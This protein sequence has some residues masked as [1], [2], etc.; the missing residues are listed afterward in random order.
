[1]ATTVQKYHEE[2]AIGKTYD[3]RIARRLFGYLRPYLGTLLPAL[4]I[5]LALTILGSAGPKITQYAIDNY[6]TK[7]NYPGLRWIALVLLGVLTARL[8][9][10]YLQDVFL[11]SIGQRV[12]YDL[13]TQIYAKLQRQEVAFYD[14]TPV[15]RIMTRLTSD[16]D[17]L[18]EL[19]TAGISDLFGDL[20]TILVIIV[21]MAIMDWRLT[22]VALYDQ[23]TG[24][25]SRF[26]FE[27]RAEQALAAAQANHGQ[28]AL[29]LANEIS[30]RN[31]APVVAHENVV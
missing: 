28:F 10:S 26:L 20:V 23:L 3:F 22:L 21:M 12:M 5:T 19:F 17:A 27:Y 25:A 7:G 1:M 24:A 2:E 4:F 14:R 31:T 30:E 29:L 8:F 15:G 18:N 16:V 11:N 9:C 13:R 6:I